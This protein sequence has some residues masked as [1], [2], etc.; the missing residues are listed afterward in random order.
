[1]ARRR[2]CR[3]VRCVIWVV[4]L[5]FALVAVALIIHSSQPAWY[6]RFWYPIGYQQAINR[7][8]RL[9]GLDPALLAAVIWRESDFD[10]TA[11]SSRG[12]VGLTQVLPST[13]T[14][15][16]AAPN[17]PVGRLADLMDPEV[18]IAYGAWY[19]RSLIDRHGGSV[20]EGLSAYNAG[21]ANLTK[22]KQQALTSGHAFQVPADVP[23]PET[24][25]YVE[26]ILDAWP[27]YRRTYGD[28]LAAPT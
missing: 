15:I 19:L 2:G 3:R 17:P 14:D 13:A 10:P 4:I 12:A 9:A 28:Q 6:A 8:A 5:G 18:N 24:K 7:E 27:I 1:M 11:R 25:A 21:S 22:W 26:D 23:F 20:V 16:A